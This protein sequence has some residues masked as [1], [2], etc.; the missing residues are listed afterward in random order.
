VTKGSSA[1]FTR[2]PGWKQEEYEAFAEKIREEVDGR[3][4]HTFMEM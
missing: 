4:Y 3:K 2:V 1:I